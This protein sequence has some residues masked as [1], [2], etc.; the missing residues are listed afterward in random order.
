MRSSLNAFVAALCTLTPALL[1]ADGLLY[2]LP[3]DGMWVEYDLTQ[4]KIGPD[5]REFMGTGLF[6]MSSVGAAVENGEKCRWIEM[7]FQLKEGERE[8]RVIAKVLIPEKH[9]Q[10]GQKPVDNIV[11]GWIKRGNRETKQLT[12]REYGPMPVILAGP[13]NDEQKLKPTVLKSK[14]GELK[15]PGV[16][17]TTVLKEGDHEIGV[18]LEIRRH[19]KS[20]F[21][22]VWA[23]VTMTEDR[24]ARR[25]RGVLTFSLRSIGNTALS[26]LPKHE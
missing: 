16:T 5:G 11:R 24:Q 17:G 25:A 18:T 14:L 19:E 4:V 20:P 7:D 23:K 9:L 13:L 8:E 6:R 1:H 3:K 22:V 21:G 26:E 10:A 15:C 12:E 2:Q